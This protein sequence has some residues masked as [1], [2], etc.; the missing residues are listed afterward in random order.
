MIDALLLRSSP[1]LPHTRA[2]VPAGSLEQLVPQPRGTIPAQDFV[3]AAV[4][5]EDLNPNSPA[6]GELQVVLVC[7]VQAAIRGRPLAWVL[8]SLFPRD[9]VTAGCIDTLV[10]RRGRRKGE[11][12]EKVEK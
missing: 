7:C 12:G 5:T 4:R 11:W 6:M 3:G 10:H 2:L 1:A 8:S 9:G